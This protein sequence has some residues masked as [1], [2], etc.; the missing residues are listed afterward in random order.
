MT[1]KNE[2]SPCGHPKSSMVTGGIHEVS[3]IVGAETERGCF[4]YCQ[5]CEGIVINDASKYIE[6]VYKSAVTI[7]GDIEF[8]SENPAPSRLR[9][10][11]MWVLLGWEWREL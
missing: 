7:N 1:D 10:W 8:H 5:E 4:S 6:S 9:R 3:S 11:L 2:L